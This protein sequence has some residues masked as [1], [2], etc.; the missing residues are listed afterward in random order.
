MTAMNRREAVKT[1]GVLL[2]G[3][4]VASS[5]MLSAC[6]AESKQPD[7][8]ARAMVLSADDQA[9]AESIADTIL[10]DTAA[11]PGAKAAGAGAAITMLLAD[12]YD[13]GARKRITDGL[14]AF[15]ASYATFVTLSQAD[16]ERLLRALDAEA[17]KSGETHWFT[18]MHELSM[19]A[20][21][22]SELGMT[23]A[24]R[25]VREPGR[26]N[27]CVTRTPGQPAWA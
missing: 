2:G 11:S 21:F 20:Y 17:T 7:V 27:G 3:A 25:Y 18:L 9:L 12:V 6:K 15:R 4:V 19:K 5:G 13:A 23:K 1:A 14:A 16:R 24:M 22:S 26:F 8:P 10:P